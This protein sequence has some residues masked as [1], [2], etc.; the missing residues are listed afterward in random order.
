MHH[1]CCADKL[2]LTLYVIMRTTTADN[3]VSYLTGLDLIKAK[4]SMNFTVSKQHLLLIFPC[5]HA[6]QSTHRTEEYQQS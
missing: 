5:W 4:C 2:I 6:E 3:A 1:G